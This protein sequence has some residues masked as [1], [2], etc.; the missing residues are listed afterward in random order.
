MS[1]GYDPERWRDFEHEGWETAAEGYHDWIGSATIQAVG[2]M[3]DAVRAGAG[4][5][6]LDVATG[7]GYVAAAAAERGASVVGADFSAAVVA[8]ASRR[9]PGVEFREAGAEALPF[10]DASFDAVTINFG[11]HHFPHPE[12]A[13]AEAHRALQP[14]GHIAFTAWGTADSIRIVPRMVQQLGDAAISLPTQ[15]PDLFG[16]PARCEHTLRAA[17]F[18]S[19]TIVTLQMVQ[20]IE[21]PEAYFEIVL[22]GAGP[23]QGTPLRAQ[24][25]ETIAAIRAAVV[26]EL[27][28]YEQDGVIH[29]PMPAILFS[30]QKP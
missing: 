10:P 9:Y 19:P 4:T 30:A 3:L 14:G 11:M 18:L 8:A 12:R 16:D 17:G 26:R 22:K 25:P 2:P 28:T 24:S 5:R 7:P 6:L 20:R 15:P 21:D 29:L 27:R 1:A 13:L 23:R